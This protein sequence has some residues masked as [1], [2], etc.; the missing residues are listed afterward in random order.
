[1]RFFLRTGFSESTESYGG[2]NK[3]CTFGLG[4]GNAATGPGFLAL[5][6]LIVNAYPCKGLGARQVSCY[7]QHLL[8][9]VAVI[10]IDDTDLPH[11]IDHVMATSLELIKHSQKLTNVWGGLAIATGVALTP[12]KCYAYFLTFHF[13][14]GRAL[15]ADVNDLPTPSCLFPQSKG[16]P[17]PSHLMVPL[18]DHTNA[19]HMVWAIV[20]WYKAYIGNVP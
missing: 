16:P 7:T 5:S 15:M 4:Q 19:L 1:M 12:K 20:P 11:M 8:I 2:S 17:L 10:Y 3:D 14:N 6:S 13:S 9:L 18:P